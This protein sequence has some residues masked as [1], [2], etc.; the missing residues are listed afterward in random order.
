MFVI[1]FIKLLWLFLNFFV[2]SSRGYNCCLYLAVL[3]SV[4][5]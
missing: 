3:S 5:S 1:G 2:P 4:I